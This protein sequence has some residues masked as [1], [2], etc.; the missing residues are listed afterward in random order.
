MYLDLPMSERLDRI[1]EL[2]AKGVYLYLKN[3]KLDNSSDKTTPPIKQIPRKNT[4]E[5]GKG[6][7]NISK[8]RTRRLY[9]SKN[10]I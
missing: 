8:L 1:G 9:S 5:D 6:H 4:M 2:L 3:Q 10:K 7:D